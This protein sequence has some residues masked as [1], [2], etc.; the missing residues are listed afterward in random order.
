VPESHG[1]QCPGRCTHIARHGRF[2]QY[3]DNFH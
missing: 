2:I 3:E 1:L